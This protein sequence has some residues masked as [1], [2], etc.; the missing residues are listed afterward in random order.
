MAQ[1]TSAEPLRPGFVIY[2]LWL[3]IDL[4]PAVVVDGA[5]SDSQRFCDM[6]SSRGKTL[7][8]DERALRDLLHDLDKEIVIAD[9]RH[10]TSA[11]LFG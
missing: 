9:I 1:P 7:S 3:V 6:V 2:T 10:W 11:H 4:S 5:A 8:L